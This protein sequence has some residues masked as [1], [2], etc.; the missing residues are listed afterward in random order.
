MNKFFRPTFSGRG[1]V[2]AGFEQTLTSPSIRE[3]EG[4]WI[5]K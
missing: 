5:K 4:Y 1:G 2:P 3:I